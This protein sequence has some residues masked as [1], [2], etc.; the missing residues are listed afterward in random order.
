[1]ISTTHPRALHPYN[2]KL[3]KPILTIYTSSSS[4]ECSAHRQVLNCKRSKPWLH[5]CRRQV[6]RRK[7][8]NKGCSFT[9]DLIGAV[10]TRC[11]PHPTLSLAYEQTLKDQKR[12]QGHQRGGE[13]RRVHSA[14]WDLLTS[15]IFTTGVKYQFLQDFLLVPGYI[16]I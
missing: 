15:P 16:N 3:M 8:R 7:L 12:S 6:Y 10:A 1:M 11:F 2:I 5:F 13:V 4:S 9:R 14:N